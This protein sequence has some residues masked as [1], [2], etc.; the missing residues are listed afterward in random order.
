MARPWTIKNKSSFTYESVAGI[1]ETIS[2][3]ENGVTEE[4]IILLRSEDHEEAL[5]ERR[6]LDNTDMIYLSDKIHYA[7]KPE[8]FYADPLEAISDPSADIF[9]ILFP[10]HQ[11][12]DPEALRA[13]ISKL[14]PQQQE[15]INEL[16]HEHRSLCDL[17]K[18]YAV[19]YGAI[20]DRRRKILARLKKLLSEAVE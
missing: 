4:W 15:L 11:N 2:V 16:Y 17:A 5:Q 7:H 20:Q 1:S 9:S 13:A 12:H 8:S 6:Q 3:G 10:E 19:T 14:T 18:Q